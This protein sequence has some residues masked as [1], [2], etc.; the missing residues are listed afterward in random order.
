MA[1][2]PVYYGNSMRGVFT[3]GERLQTVHVPFEKLSPGDIVAVSGSLQYV[4]RIIRISGDIAVTMGDNNPLPDKEL[5][6]PQS[7][8][9]R[10]VGTVQPDGNIKAVKSGPAGMS[11]FLKNQRRRKFRELSL[12]TLSLLRPLS[13]LRIPVSAHRRFGGNTVFYFW[14]IPV[15][16]RNTAGQ[17]TYRSILCRLLFRK[18]E[19]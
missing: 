6:S 13:F 9:L 1:E 5:L 15:F 4:H 2:F 3:P 10:V 8:F 17:I 18:G 11:L 16:H 14:N 12:R 7:S 19:S